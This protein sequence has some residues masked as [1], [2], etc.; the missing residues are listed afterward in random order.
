MCPGR[1]RVENRVGVVRTSLVDVASLSPNTVG[2]CPLFYTSCPVTK[3]RAR[4]HFTAVLSKLHVRIAPAL[5][6]LLAIQVCSVKARDVFELNHGVTK[7]WRQSFRR[8][9]PEPA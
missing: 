4:H 6:D 9:N 8:A 7:R 5:D 2:A 1:H 3:S